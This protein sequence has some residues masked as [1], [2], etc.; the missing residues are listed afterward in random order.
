MSGPAEPTAD[1]MR[2]MINGFRTT[3]VVY[4]F[5]KLGLADYPDESPFTAAGLAV[6]VGANADGLGRVLRLAALF[7][8][9]TEEPGGRFRL[10][11]LGDSLKTDKPN[12]LRQVAIQLGEL[13]YG[14]WGGLLHSAKTGNSAFEHIFGA[15]LFDYLSKHPDAQTTFDAYMSANKDLFADALAERYDFARFRVLVDVGGGNGSVSAAIL[16]RNPRLTALIFDQPQVVRTAA[17][18]LSATGLEKRCQVVGGDFFQSVPPGGDIYMLSN[19]IHDW[20][21]ASARRILSNCRAVMQPDTPL[22]LLEAILS[23]HGESSGVVMSDVNMLVM[24]TGRERTEDQYDALL[25]ASGLTLSR[26]I[27]ITQRLSL[28]EC[29]RSEVTV[30]RAQG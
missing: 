23:P 12:S 26:T 13:H 10:T 14:G 11:P 1:R 3:Q 4:V 20:D 24:L 16:K 15:S 7:G 28:I 30:A 9:V 25:R 21:D 22:I 19:V 18:F 27:P 6:R 5:A 29:L 2:A 17:Q 8:L